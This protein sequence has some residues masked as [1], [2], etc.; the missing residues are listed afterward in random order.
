MTNSFLFLP[1]REGHAW[2]GGRRCGGRHT[3]ALERTDSSASRRARAF[4]GHAAW[5]IKSH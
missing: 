1:T 5:L 4:E 3:R 2:H